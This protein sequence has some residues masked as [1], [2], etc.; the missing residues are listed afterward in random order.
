MFEAN[1]YIFDLM[2]ISLYTADI[3]DREEVY[4]ESCRS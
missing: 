4:R 1:F 3:S 2:H